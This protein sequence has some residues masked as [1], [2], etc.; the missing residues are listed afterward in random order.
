MPAAMHNLLLTQHCSA[1][2][3]DVCVGPI[4]W[5]TDAGDLLPGTGMGL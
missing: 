1:W 3:G 4:P 5:H 2:G